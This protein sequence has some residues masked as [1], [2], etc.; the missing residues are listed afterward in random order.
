MPIIALMSHETLSQVQAA[1]RLGATSMLNKP[2]CTKRRLHDIYDGAGP[3]RA[4][5]VSHTVE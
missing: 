1:V 3:G 4:N 2:F 5:R